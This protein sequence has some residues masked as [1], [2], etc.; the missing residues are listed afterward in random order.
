MTNAK[1]YDQGEHSDGT[2]SAAFAQNPS[3]WHFKGRVIS[4]LRAII[5]GDCG[6]TELYVQHPAMIYDA[7]QP[8]KE[9]ENA[10]HERGDYRITEVY[11]RNPAMLYD[12]FQPSNEA[13]IGSGDRCLKCGARM[14]DETSECETCGWT[15]LT[16]DPV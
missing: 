1:R 12:A 13:K 6:Y 3:A 7:F 2:L 15:Y 14:P 4:D 9:A 16:D 10:S 11:A 8:S 5:C